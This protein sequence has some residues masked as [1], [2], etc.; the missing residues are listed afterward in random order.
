MA[1]FQWLL[2]PAVTILA[3]IV[4]GYLGVQNLRNALTQRER[5]AG[6]AEGRMEAKLEV[7]EQRLRDIDVKLNTHDRKL[8]AAGAKLDAHGAKLDAHD[9]LLER[10]VGETK[11]LSR[12]V[13]R[14]TKRV[15]ALEPDGDPPTDPRHGNLRVISR[16]DAP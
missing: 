9:L 8:D 4:T 7:I 11:K 10:A 5:D 3:V 6:H 16:N 2:M 14:L 1:D 15:E 13:R 12:R